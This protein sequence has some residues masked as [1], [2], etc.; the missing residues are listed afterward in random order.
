[1][2]GKRR[3]CND[4]S[5]FGTGEGNEQTGDVTYSG[6]LTEVN[7]LV[8]FGSTDGKIITRSTTSVTSDV[9][10]EIADGTVAD[11]S[12]AFISQ[13]SSGFYKSASGVSVSNAGGEI[14]TIDSK[15]I[16][17]LAGSAAAPS[18]SFI[19]DS[20]AGVYNPIAGTC[21][22]TGGSNYMQVSGTHTTFVNPI[23]NNSGTLAEPAYSFN[24]EPDTGINNFGS[25][26]IELVSNSQPTVRSTPTGLLLDSR[27]DT[28]A[29]N[30]LL[31]GDTNATSVEVG[32]D[33]LIEGRLDTIGADPLLIGNTNATSINVGTGS[34]D[35]FINGT[36]NA[37]LIDVSA[38]GQIQIGFT[39]A[40]PLVLSRTGIQ[41][42]VKGQLDVDELLR[43][44]GDVDLDNV[45]SNLGLV[46]SVGHTKAT[47]VNL[48]RT[49]ELT[50]VKGELLVDEN[51][52]L[53]AN[54]SMGPVSGGLRYCNVNTPNLGMNGV[55]LNNASNFEEFWSFA[56][57]PKT[58]GYPYKMNV[59]HKEPNGLTFCDFMTFEHTAVDV[60]N[61]SKMSTDAITLGTSSQRWDGVYCD[62][63]DVGGNAL[64][65]NKLDAAL[66]GGLLRL[67][68]DSNNVDI[69]QSGSDTIVFGNLEVKEDFVH[70][71]AFV[72][73]YGQAM[74]NVTS[75]ILA[76]TD[77]LV[78]FG[79]NISS[80]NNN[81]FTT[82]TAGRLTY[83]GART[84]FFHC[85]A[86]ISFSD[87]KN[88]DVIFSIYKNGV[89]VPGS[90]VKLSAA[91]GAT[92][93]AIHKILS[94]ATNQYI[95]LIVQSDQAMNDITVEYV[96]LFALQLPNT[97]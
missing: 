80:T 75:A 30:S 90:Q 32:T 11:P 36:L 1:M 79:A 7:G 60:G 23:R 74:V 29:A 51:A 39:N 4:R 47:N 42:Q 95:E 69:S 68:T 6:G 38:P 83:T 34:A 26:V 27:L 12:L 10:I 78:N 24:A 19:A 59:F 63:L 43:C 87:T 40:N 14:A 94:L 89:L 17:G 77:Y 56:H 93:T 70:Q 54:T 18:F 28:I 53:Q 48:S 16:R 88:A 50:E 55:N 62:A 33:T 92:S 5:A 21:G 46:I 72:D 81:E 20:T 73:A 22:V 85:G 66:P 44:N 3:C 45:D 91:G 31:V 9:P 67:G 49:G 61:I 97:V 8:A 65:D 64:V 84:S 2:F 82:S 41:T 71:D 13:P 15:S 52:H 25:G 96:N 57:L 86:T 35:T 58:S 37:P 76:N